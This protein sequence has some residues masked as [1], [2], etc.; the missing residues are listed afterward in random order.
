MTAKGRPWRSVLALVLAIAAAAVSGSTRR[1][2]PHF[3][4]TGDPATIPAQLIC[5]G[6]A[7]AFAGFGGLAVYSLAGQARA[8]L[9][10]N[11]SS[12]SHAAMVR[13]AMLLIGGLSVLV[14]TL[15][16][17]GIPIGQLVLGGALTSVIFGLAAQQSL[18]NVFAGLVL[19]IGRPFRVGQFVRLRAG[20]LGANG[21]IDGTVLDIGITYVRMDTGE[22]IM[23]IPNSMALAC[24]AGPAPPLTESD[25][26]FRD[27]PRPEPLP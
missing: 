19:L 25:P 2:F 15:G 13:Y 20:A 24:I 10:R 23:S 5:A 3:F 14:I 17:F 21:I 7:L 4:D 26:E 1:Q 6:C 11:R 18:G 27:A 9:E 16:L 22:S 12:A 8:A